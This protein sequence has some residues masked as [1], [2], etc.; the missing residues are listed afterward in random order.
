MVQ[1]NDSLTVSVKGQTREFQRAMASVESRIAKMERSVERD[2][3]GI[4]RSSQRAARAMEQDF[5]RSTARTTALFTRMRGAAVGSLAGL[6]VGVGAIGSASA[7]RGIREAASAVAA[8]GDQADKVGLTVEQLQALRIEFEK[9]G[10]QTSALDT[11]FQRFSRRV[12][13]AAQGTGSLHSTMQELGIQLTNADGSLRPIIDIFADYAEAIKNADSQQEALRLT[14]KAFD[15]EGAGMVNLLRQIGAGARDMANSFN[16]R[17]NIITSE[18]VAKA[19]E[20]DAAFADMARELDIVLKK[21]ALGIGPGLI[22][23]AEAAATVGEELT[24]W[25]AKITTFAERLKDFVFPSPEASLEWLPEGTRLIDETE[26]A[27][28]GVNNRLRELQQENERLEAVAERA[29]RLGLTAKLE[30]S[31][32]KIQQNTEEVQRLIQEL[33]TLQGISVTPL[34]GTAPPGIGPTG[35]DARGISTIDGRDARTFVQSRAAHGRVDAHGLKQAAAAGAAAVL[36]MFP[37]L[38]VSSAYRSREYNRSVDGARNSRHIERDAVDFVGVTPQNVGAIVAA[39]QAQG[40]NA[41]GYYNNGSLHADMRPSRAAW[42]P[43]RTGAS[44][45]RTP[46]EF[47]RAVMAGPQVSP[48]MGQRL[49]QRDLAA[50]EA[51]ALDAQREAIELRREDIEARRQQQEAIDAVNE[52]LA[53]ELE[54]AGLEKEMLQAG[55]FTLEEVRNALDQ[56]ALVREKLN[57]LKQAGVEVTAALEE[58]IRGEVAALFEL[59]SASE[60]AIVAQ[61]ELTART[62][63]LQSAAVSVAQPILD[64]FLSIADGSAKAE[65]AIK[66]LILQLAKMLIQGSLFGQGPLGALFGGGLFGSLFGAPGRAMGGPVGRGQPY[67]VGERGRELFVPDS[68]GTII[69]AN[70]TRQMMARAAQPLTTGGG[71]GGR[72]P[73]QEIRLTATFDPKSEDKIAPVFTNIA[74]LEGGKVTQSGIAAYDRRTQEARYRTG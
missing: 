48:E 29:I 54:A 64:T 18:D 3:G 24:S 49:W 6:G 8:L 25:I 55:K 14:F 59:R 12:G 41:F 43:D 66:R 40:F 67:I 30:D 31:R 74:R 23:V 19:R 42:G 7:I 27:V 17:T 46:Q 60:Q 15:T 44:L 32:S 65:D 5:A 28:A 50:N 39:L 22:T 73:V 71:M 45:H 11:G 16:N 51:A 37:E 57:Q 53:R 34:G 33:Y 4:R 1:D 70:R 38:R 72:A 63:E 69:D 20:I 10:V 47:Q 62:Q 21:I 36:Q 52:S 58:R 56:E 9:A 26:R 2:M 13:E 35:G 68:N 61:Q